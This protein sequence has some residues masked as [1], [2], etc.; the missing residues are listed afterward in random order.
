MKDRAGLQSLALVAQLG[1]SIA[2][3]MVAF[4]G[5]GAWLDGQLG[6]VPWL[7]FVGIV[8]GLVSA[9]AALYQLT[10]VPVSRRGGPK[11]AGGK[12]SPQGDLGTVHADRRDGSP[13]D[14]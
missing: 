6:T 3:P 14:D 2:C 12:G 11:S 4:I 13:D 5:G 7:L 8:L 10:K 1:F 9:G